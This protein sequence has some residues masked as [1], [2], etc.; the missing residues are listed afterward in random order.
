MKRIAGAMCLIM[1]LAGTGFSIATNQNI[2]IM[3]SNTTLE[4]MGTM[5]ATYEITGYD[6]VLGVDATNF[7]FSHTSV[8]TAIEKLQGNR[9]VLKIKSYEVSNFVMP[10][11]MVTAMRAGVTDTF[12]TPAFPVNN[13]ALSKKGTNI[14]PIWGVYEMPDFLPL[15]VAL[16]AI[17]VVGAIVL[18]VF[19]MLPMFKKSE[20]APETVIDP[21]AEIE[22]LLTQLKNMQVS[23]ENYKEFFSLLSEGVRRFLERILLFPALEMATSEIRARMKKEVFD[24][25]IQEISLFVLKLCDRVKYAKHQAAPEQ[26]GEALSESENLVARVRLLYQAVE[27]ET[28]NEKD[29]EEKK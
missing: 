20:N 10:P 6:K 18:I 2:N 7:D 19:K 8:E 26:I 21:Y 28:G 9:F 22:T 17:A 13:T 16:I 14:A 25:E 27:K 24:T 11:L 15:I 1:G 5:R 12:Y 23:P 3:F 4:F 29:Q